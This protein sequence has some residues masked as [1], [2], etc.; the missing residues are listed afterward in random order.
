MDL[1]SLKYISGIPDTFIKK[2]YF[3]SKKTR[4][5]DKMGLRFKMSL[6]S[7]VKDLNLRQIVPVRKNVNADLRQIV[8]LLISTGTI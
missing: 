4:T 3:L 5:K 7:H 8:P 2:K 6:L 1:Y